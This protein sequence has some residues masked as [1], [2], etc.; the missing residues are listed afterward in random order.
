MSA[1][2]ACSG[3]P[4]VAQPPSPRNS[5]WLQHSEQK[6]C[7]S[8]ITTPHPAQRGGSAKSSAQVAQVRIVA[9]NISPRLSRTQRQRTS[10]A[11]SPELFDMELRALRRDRAFRNGVELFLYERAFAD[12]LDRIGLVQQS[13]RSALLIGCPDPDWPARLGELADQVD[14]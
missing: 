7:T 12:C 11:A 10:A 14:T 1:S 13:F 4:Q 5:T 6:L 2:V 3:M 9:P 8:E